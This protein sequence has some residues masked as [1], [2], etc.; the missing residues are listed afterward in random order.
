MSHNA[1]KCGATKRVES[2]RCRKCAAEAQ[3]ASANPERVE[4][5]QALARRIR[6]HCADTGMRIGEFIAAGGL[7]NSFLTHLE[8]GQGG[9]EAIL[10]AERVL[11]GEKLAQPPQPAKQLE[12]KLKLHEFARETRGPG[13]T[14]H[15][16]LQEL[17]R[18]MAS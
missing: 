14:A 8:R 16:R 4:K 17:Q 18:E 2:K 1:C 15:A 7:S 13:Q 3:R 6:Q 9:Y 12:R 10:R 5:L 11:R